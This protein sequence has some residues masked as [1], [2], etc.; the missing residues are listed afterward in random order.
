MKA[1]VKAGITQVF[2]LDVIT[3]VQSVSP[4][5]LRAAQVRSLNQY[6]PLPRKTTERVFHKIWISSQSE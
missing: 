1:A 3:H 5:S 6:A 2:D 4:R